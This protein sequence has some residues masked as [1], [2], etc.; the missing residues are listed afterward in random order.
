MSEKKLYNVH[1]FKFVTDT[2]EPVTA[3]GFAALERVARTVRGVNVEVVEDDEVR[4]LLVTN[5]EVTQKW[6]DYALD[7]AHNW[8]ADVDFIRP[9]AKGGVDD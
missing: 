8:R 7:L 4:V 2:I 9:T 3:H 6:K 1:V 5:L